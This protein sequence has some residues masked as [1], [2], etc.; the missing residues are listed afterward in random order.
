MLYPLAAQALVKRE[1]APAEPSAVGCT[2][3]D[4]L[5]RF[6][7][8][9]PGRLLAPLDLGAFVLAASRLEVVGAPYHRNNAGNLAVY[10]FFLGTPDEAAA[11]AR[12]WQIGYVALCADSFSELGDA[13]A[14][15]GRMVNRLQGGHVP[16]WLQP[17]AVAPGGLAVYRIEPRL[18]RQPATR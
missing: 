9:P 2:A 12:D 15:D 1:P 7:R 3:P 5:A 14:G 8:L 6:G 13:A 18:F 17:V 10:R 11:I 4:A 16:D